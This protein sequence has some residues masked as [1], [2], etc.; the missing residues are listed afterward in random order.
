MPYAHGSDLLCDFRNQ[1]LHLVFT[2]ANELGDGKRAYVRSSA[3]VEDME[4]MSGAGLYESVPNVD[5]GDADELGAAIAAV[6]ASLYTQRAVLTR[7]A[8]G[9]IPKHT[10]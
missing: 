9:E 10:A 4:G 1:R 3:N 7:R 2:A 8:A 5:L 6:W